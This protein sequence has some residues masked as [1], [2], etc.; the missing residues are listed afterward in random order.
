MWHHWI[1]RKKGVGEIYK[2][3]LERTC[4]RNPILLR[5]VWT[6]AIPRSVILHKLTQ[7]SGTIASSQFSDGSVNGSVNLSVPQMILFSACCICGLIGGILNFQF[8]RA[9]SKRPD[10]MSSIHL[11]AMTLACLGKQLYKGVSA[12]L[13]MWL[14]VY[15]GSAVHLIFYL[16]VIQTP[17]FVL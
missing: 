1:L 6:G 3:S 4:E 10:S 13:E 9:L 12:S 17:E 11:A 5:F 8:V 2:Q 16:L 7:Q 15:E 14:H